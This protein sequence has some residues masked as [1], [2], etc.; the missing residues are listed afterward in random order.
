[1][2]DFLGL[3]FLLFHVNLANQEATYLA[4]EIQVSNICRIIILLQLHCPNP[5][6]LLKAAACIPNFN[7][8]TPHTPPQYHIHSMTH[9]FE[10]I[11]HMSE[12]D[13]L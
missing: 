6:L 1:M 4:Y 12:T 11:T 8:S 3:F 10:H 9:S 7:Y 13:L 5:T 2:V